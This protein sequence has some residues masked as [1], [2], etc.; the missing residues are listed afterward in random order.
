M[1]AMIVALAGA[2]SDDISA[3]TLNASK[4]KPDDWRADLRALAI[5]LPKRHVKAFHTIGQTEFDAAIAAL[6][7]VIPTATPDRIVTGMASI[8]ASV[9]D[10]HTQLKLPTNWPRYAIVTQWF[11]CDAQSVGPCELRVTRAASEHEKMLARVWSPLM[12][13]PSARCTRG[14]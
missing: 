6:D 13:A 7:A 11:G 10:G 5:E 14:C 8:A 9:G 2:T 4:L 12:D 1:A 3:Q